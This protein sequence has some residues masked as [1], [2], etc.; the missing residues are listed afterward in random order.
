M[1]KATVMSKP[2]APTPNSKNSN[3]I[4][5]EDMIELFSLVINLHLDLVGAL[6]N[7]LT[8]QTNH[9]LHIF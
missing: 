9:K 4:H 8:T 5:V 3:E 2:I 6:S 1:A 7:I